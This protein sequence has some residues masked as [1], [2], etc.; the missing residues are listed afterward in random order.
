MLSAQLLF[1]LLST[2]VP[3]D[4]VVRI[5]N[6]SARYDYQA[7][8][9]ILPPESGLGSGFVIGP[10]R[11]L[12]NAH[13]VRDSRQVVVKKHHVAESFVAKVEVSGNDCDLAVLTV[14]DPAFMKG[15][16]ALELGDLPK[17]RSMVVT[18]GYP[19]GGQEVSSTKGI[20]SRVEMKLYVHSEGDAHI[21]VQ[22]DAAINPGNSG[23]PVIQDGKVVGVAFQ[24]ASA[25]QNVAFF[26]PAPIVRHF[27][28][29][30][31]DQRYDGFP[32]TAAHFTDLVSP[33]LRKERGLQ[34][35]QTG[36]VV[37][38]IYPDGTAAGALMV[39][40][41]LLAIDGQS[42]ANDGTVPLGDARV[43]FGHLLDMKQVGAPV[44]FKVWREGKN[45]EVKGP[46]RR[47]AR[48]DRQ[49]NR[50]GVAPKYFVYAGLVFMP[51][52]REYLKTFGDEW[53]MTVPREMAWRLFYRAAEEPAKAND[54]TVVLARVLQH[55]VNSQ[56]AAQS[57]IIQSINGVPASDLK[58]VAS[59]INGARAKGQGFIRLEFE[60]GSV[61]AIDVAEGEAAHAAIMRTYGISRDQN[62]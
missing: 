21:A 39:G 18:Y 6:Y 51:L 25:L 32:D 15:T 46:S 43:N 48:G 59:A 49:R 38:D 16:K 35:E 17:A 19:S 53:P 1:A 5:Q 47:L 9:K 26:I 34:K 12:T 54:E 44:S 52:D 4:S 45:V 41:V 7:P 40:D 23:G 10:G 61:E 62:L 11:I 30:L 20:V 33:A 27:L 42:I 2:A 28:D 31:G 37:D 50:Y 24:G 14:D 58:A 36:V 57:G 55:P 22:T 29:D 60:S 56:M 8:W 3:E 13:V